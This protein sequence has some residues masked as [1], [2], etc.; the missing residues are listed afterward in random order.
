MSIR[1]ASS[2][3]FVLG[4][5]SAFASGCSSSDDKL[6]PLPPAGG[7]GGAKAGSGG[8]L[9]GGTSGSA[10]GGGRSGDGGAGEG[11]APGGD[12]GTPAAGAPTGEGGVTAGAGGS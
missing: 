9:S 6:S 11:G 7:T 10:V 4:L 8:G 1:A 2:V 3:V 12:G 5:S